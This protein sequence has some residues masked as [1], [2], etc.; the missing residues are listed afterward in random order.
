MEEY[1][2]HVNVIG[3]SSSHAGQYD[4]RISSHTSRADFWLWNNN[5][6]DIQVVAGQF[7]TIAEARSFAHEVFGEYNIVED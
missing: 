7:N 3:P 5:H 4:V 1:V 2:F 6:N